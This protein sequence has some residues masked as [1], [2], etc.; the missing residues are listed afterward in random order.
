M[1]RKVSLGSL[2][3]TR[4]SFRKK[5]LS[6]GVIAVLGFTVHSISR[7]SETHGFLINATESLPNWAFFIQSGVFPTR[8]D[9][10]IFDPG[11]DPIVTEYFGEHPSLFAK[12]TYGVAG[13]LVERRGNEVYVNGDPVARLKPYTRKGDKLTA[14]PVGVIPKGCVYAGSHHKDGFDSRYANIGF[15]C[16]DRLVGVGTP[17]L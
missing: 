4:L 8:G 1:A 6:L 2:A 14:G 12:I 16:K 17:I 9:Y 11:D 15:V 13:D 5:M 10:V 7:W 3:R